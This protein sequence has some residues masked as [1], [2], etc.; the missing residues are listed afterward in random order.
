MS[1]E[2]LDV[3]LIVIVLGL[4]GYVWKLRK[5]I[6]SLIP[7]E[8]DEKVLDMIEGAADSLGIDVEDL[9]KKSRGKL[10]NQVKKKF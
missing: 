4:L 3:S 7:G 1:F 10:K 8:M 6:T 2:I 9:A 5:Q